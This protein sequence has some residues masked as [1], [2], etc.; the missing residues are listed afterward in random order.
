MSGYVLAIDQGTT[1]SRAIV[2]DGEQRI[3]GLGKME[4]SREAEVTSADDEH[5]SLER[6]LQRRR[7][8]RCDRSLFPKIGVAACHRQVSSS[9]G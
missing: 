7:R 1:S 5:V 6:G 9:V 2:F 4:R 8:W 3:A